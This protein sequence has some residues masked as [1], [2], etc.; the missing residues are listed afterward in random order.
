MPRLVDLGVEPYLLAPTLI[1]VVGQRLVRRLCPDCRT[2]APDAP[3][4][5]SALK[6]DLPTDLPAHL[7]QAHGCPECNQT[8][9]R[10]RT[11]IHEYLYV[12]PAFAPA[13]S[14]GVNTTRLWELAREMGFKT[15]FEDGVIKSMRGI[16]TLE[17]ILRVTQK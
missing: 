4:K 2:P 15:M 12:D 16:T 10:G 5:L 7:W 3:E 1:G 6:L 9:Y 8:G 13:I 14:H 11:G 17:E